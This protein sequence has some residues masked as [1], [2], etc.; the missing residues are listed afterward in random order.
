MV[1]VVDACVFHDWPS[2]HALVP[3]LPA[4]WG[5]LVAA[6]T[7]RGAPL[8]VKSHWRVRDPRGAQAPSSFPANGVPGSDPELLVEQLFGSGERDRVVLGY[9]DGLLATAYGDPFLTR[10]VV[11]AV[12]DWTIAEWLER[13]ERF[14]AHVLVASQSPADAAAEIRRVGTHE[15]MVAVALGANVLARGFGHLVYHP[16]YEAAAELGL[17][18]V[19]HA[20]CDS[21]TDSISLPT[22]VGLPGTYAEYEAMSAHG[23]MSHVASMIVAG[24]FEL[25]PTLRVLLVGG[26]VSWVPWW[27]WNTDWTFKIARRIEAPGLSRRPSD[28]FC[29]HV[30]LTTYQLEVPAEQERLARLLDVVPGIESMLLYASGYPNSDLIGPAAVAG[31]LPEAWHERVFRGNAEELYRLPV[32]APSVGHVGEGGGQ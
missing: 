19:L 7:G 20:G 31:A 25:Y 26:G 12:N 29:D 15:R 28:Y 21:T 10:E 27:M 8:R 32:A 1:P 2:S 16:V 23:L 5:K 17:P 3:Y 9:H 14:L 22:A 13:D 11:R 30:R 6:G 4:G 18:V 24:V